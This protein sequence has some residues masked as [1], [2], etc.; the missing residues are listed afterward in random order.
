MF[1][2]IVAALLI[3][4]VASDPEHGEEC[5]ASW[6]HYHEG[7][8]TENGVKIFYHFFEEHPEIKADFPKFKDVD[9]AHLKELP[10]FKEHATKIFHVI[11]DAVM[12]QNWEDVEKLSKFHFD[13]HQTDKAK[14]D[15]F[16]KTFFDSVTKHDATHADAWTHCLDKFFHHFYHHF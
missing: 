7:D 10:A 3:G 8:A 14:F 12:K 11:D 9:M 5:K 4:A 6:K 16:R 15:A 2:Y 1:K 13:I